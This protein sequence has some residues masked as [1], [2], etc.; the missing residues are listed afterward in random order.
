M[1]A[2]KDVDNTELGEDDFQDVLSAVG[3]LAGT[4]RP[5]AAVLGLSPAA[6]KEIDEACRGIPAQCLSTAIDRWLRQEYNY[7][8]HGPPS[9]SKLVMAVV[10]NVGGQN[11]A[12]AKKIA[13]SHR[14]EPDQYEVMTPE[15]QATVAQAQAELTSWEQPVE[16]SEGRHDEQP[17]EVATTQKSPSPSRNETANCGN[18]QLSVCQQ[19]VISM[20]DLQND[21]AQIAH[22]WY[23]IGLL[24]GVS[25]HDLDKISRDGSDFQ[26]LLSDMLSHWLSNNATATRSDLEEMLKS[27]IISEPKLARKLL[28]IKGTFPIWSHK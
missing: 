27:K 21:L 6:L 26:R 24:L 25:A 22:K 18:S 15:A 16:V 7:E 5:F 2:W 9:W 3:E 8:R 20:K 4:W 1:S 14:I 17:M 12:L 10:S 11:A 19:R 28:S 23:N 13:Q